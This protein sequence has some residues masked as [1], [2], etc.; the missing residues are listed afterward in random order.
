MKAAFPHLK[1]AGCGRVIN[2][3]S[4]AGQRGQ[5]GL[6]CYVAT[7]EAIRGITR[8]AAREWGPYGITVNV[9][10]PWTETE[11]VTAFK[12]EQPETYA[13]LLATVPMRRA[14][15]SLLDIAPFMVFLASDGGGY[16]TGA[17][18]NI[19]GGLNLFP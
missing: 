19:E 1:A 12:N 17:T 4:S 10:C 7:K 16:M 3:G 6:T 8:T 5:E 11:P 18:F 15:D 9:M 14:G 13:A 2:F